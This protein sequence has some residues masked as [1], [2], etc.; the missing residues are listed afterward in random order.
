MRVTLRVREVVRKGSA[1]HDVS[2]DTVQ[3]PPH[4]ASADEVLDDPIK[5]EEAARKQCGVG[6]SALDNHSLPRV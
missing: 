4:L 6:P 5:H 1:A 2:L 3:A